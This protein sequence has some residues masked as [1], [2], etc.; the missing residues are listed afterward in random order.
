M[1]KLN[2]KKKKK[3][4][5]EIASYKEANKERCKFEINKKIFP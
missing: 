2:K 4:I 3:V 1:Y 5:R